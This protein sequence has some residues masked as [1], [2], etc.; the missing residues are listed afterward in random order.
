MFKHSMLRAQLLAE[1]GKST[2]QWRDSVYVPLGDQVADALIYLVELGCIKQEKILE[3]LPHPSRS[4]SERIAYFLGKKAR[5]DL[6][7]KTDPEKLEIARI[8]LSCYLT[9]GSRQNL[10]S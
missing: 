3:G 2:K 5:S 10:C 6:S 7:I 1:F 9:S 4:N 8:R